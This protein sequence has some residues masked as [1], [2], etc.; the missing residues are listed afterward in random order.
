MEF[1]GGKNGIFGKND[2]ILL[3]NHGILGKFMEF[4]GKREFWGKKM[5]FWE[6]GKDFQ[7]PKPVLEV[8]G[9]DSQIFRNFFSWEN[10]G[11]LFRKK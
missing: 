4:Y 6:L 8:G 3:E 9:G 2:G 7:S 11:F 10:L 1:C 5:E